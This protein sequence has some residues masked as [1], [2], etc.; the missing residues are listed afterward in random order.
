MDEIDEMR[1]MYCNDGIEEMD[2]MCGVVE[3]CE[4][5][6]LDGMYEIGGMS[7]MDEIDRTRLR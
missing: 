3:I 1:G 5:Y 7:G 2:E 6:G 4:M